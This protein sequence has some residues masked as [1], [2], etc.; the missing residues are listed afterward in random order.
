MA[1]PTPE[2][3]SLDETDRRS[4]SYLGAALQRRFKIVF[5][6]L[7]LGLLLAVLAIALSPSLYRARVRVK[8]EPRE[9]T[10]ESYPS[11]DARTA[12]EKHFY[13]TQVE[14]LESRSLAKMVIRNLRL[15]DLQEFELK[16][17]HERRFEMRNGEGLGAS[18]SLG[19]SPIASGTGSVTVSATEPP[20][21]NNSA[22]RSPIGETLLRKLA[23]IDAPAPAY[24][25]DADL[26]RLASIYL[27]RLTVHAVRE[28]PQLIDL[29][30]ASADPELAAEVAEEHARLYIG[31]RAF[32]NIGLTAEYI[33][34]LLTRK[35]DAETNVRALNRDIESFKTEHDY[36]EIGDVTPVQEVEN[37]LARL[38]QALSDADVAVRAA[39][40]AHAALFEPG[41]E[42][43]LDFLLLE[44]V[45][46]PGLQGLAVEQARIYDAWA[47]VSGRY[48]P[49]HPRFIEAKR[50]K[51]EID[52]RMQETQTVVVQQAAS[53]LSRARHQYETALDTERRLLEDK[54]ALNELQKELDSLQ[55]RRMDW[56]NQHGEA[57][58]A[59]QQAERNVLALNSVDGGERLELVEAAEIPLTPHSQDLLANAIGLLLIF[60]VGG[61][62]AAFV[63]D[64]FDTTIRAPGEI[65]RIMRC[66]SLGAISHVPKNGQH[67]HAPIL[68]VAEQDPHGPAVESFNAL[69]SSVFFASLRRPLKNLLVTSPGSGEGK[70]TVS[71]NLAIA[72]ANAGKRIVLVDGDLRNPSL[73]RAFGHPSSPGLV[74]VLEE[75]EGLDDLLLD[76]DVPRLRFMPAGQTEVSPSNLF[77]AE[78]FLRALAR[79]EKTADF[80]ILDSSPVLC[81]VDASVI[82][83]NVDGVVL[84]TRFGQTKR[85][86]AQTAAERLHTAGGELFGFVVNDLPQRDTVT[87]ANHAYG[88]AELYRPGEA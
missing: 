20:E 80:V 72:L 87:Y 15:F 50:R 61:L 71:L 53:E 66:A 27:D 86:A 19:S 75:R 5:A 49:N 60:S 70:S 41:H 12:G 46:S 3:F 36:W 9:S 13:R 45:T 65:E 85:E 67:R 88:G 22:D 30:F 7:G 23:E 56:E 79:L 10:A 11:L 25:T 33:D 74:D 4:F 17:V 57:M 2:R 18:D 28:T 35:D 29:Y 58:A 63:V 6:G 82:A 76:T 39:V 78:A 81:A 59:L 44:T 69:R 16:S 21:S 37:R 43:D 73:H 48:G 83:R 1:H 34:S 77:I 54:V 47:D 24:V 14:L 84:V 40:S 42:G 62:I 51:D 64:R 68:R 32:S 8:V 52:R 31:L 55:R 26:S 38:R